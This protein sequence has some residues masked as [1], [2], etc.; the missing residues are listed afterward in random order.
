ML[1]DEVWALTS[2]KTIAHIHCTD[3]ILQKVRGEG[4]M[5]EDFDSARCNAALLF[6]WAKGGE[7]VRRNL[8]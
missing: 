2:I 5:P 6:M 4:L 8:R 1:V 7:H 3:E